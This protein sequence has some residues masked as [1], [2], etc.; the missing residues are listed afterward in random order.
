MAASW[1]RPSLAASVAI[2]SAV[3]SVTQPP[4]VKPTTGARATQAAQ[5]QASAD[6]AFTHVIDYVNSW[7]DEP[8]RSLQ[9]GLECARRAVALDDDEPQAHFA[10]AIACLWDREL[11]RALSEARR[12]L[13]LAP[14]LADGHLATAHIQIFAGEP[15]LA[16][17]A[18]R[19]AMQLDP[20]YPDIV[21]HFLAE[22]HVSLRQ[23][24]PAVSVL[25][26]RL[27]RNIS[28]E[29]TLALLASCYGH[30]GR[31]RES[32]E[33]WAEVMRLNPAFSMERRRSVLPFRNGSDFELRIEGLRKAGLLA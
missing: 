25:R 9:T 29:T 18:I 13:A 2:L 19:A 6:I 26:Q 10:M 28:S 12:C 30:L 27:D 31:A 1:A 24:E 4:Q 8:Q 22:A 32:R 15:A 17:E 23:F 14:N 21:L 3:L 33:A 16:V 20:L 7:A 11:D 5:D